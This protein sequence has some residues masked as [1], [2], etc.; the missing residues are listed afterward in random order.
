MFDTLVIG[1]GISGLTAAWK[2][3]AK[4]ANVL[5]LEKNEARRGAYQNGR[6]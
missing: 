1:G 4:G 3:K 2:L 6:V 5:V